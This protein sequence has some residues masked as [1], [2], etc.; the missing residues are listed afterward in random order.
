MCLL[1]PRKPLLRL[2]RASYTDGPP[3]LASSRWNLD[4]ARKA[5]IR[6]KDGCCDIEQPL[7]PS[8]RAGSSA[9]QQ[10]T[11]Q[12][13]RWCCATGLR[14]YQA[15]REVDYKG[16]QPGI[17]PK[18]AAAKV[19][20]ECELRESVNG[21]S[22]L[23][24]CLL[25]VLACIATGDCV[26]PP[27]MRF[28]NA[29]PNRPA[30]RD[31]PWL[32]QRPRTASSSSRLTIDGGGMPDR[33]LGSASVSPSRCR[34]PTAGPQA[35]LL[36]GEDFARAS[37]A[38]SAQCCC[39]LLAVPAETWRCWRP[40]VA[41]AEGLEV[42]RLAS[43]ASRLASVSAS[44]QIL[45]QRGDHCCCCCA[46]VAA[47][48]TSPL[49]TRGQPL[50]VLVTAARPS[51][52]LEW[53]G[54]PAVSPTHDGPVERRRRQRIVPTAGL[55]CSPNLPDESSARSA[56]PALAV[57]HHQA[58][59]CAPSLTEALCHVETGCDSAAPLLR[60]AHDRHAAA[61]G[62]PSSTLA[63]TPFDA[64]FE[65]NC[66]SRTTNHREPYTP[67][68]LQ[69]TGAE[70]ASFRA[71][72]EIMPSAAPVGRRLST[73]TL[74]GRQERKVTASSLS[75]DQ[76]RSK[77]S[78]DWMEECAVTTTTRAASY[79]LQ[80]HCRGLGPSGESLSRR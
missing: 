52:A 9:A 40:R 12:P 74:L 47:L 15:R 45:W 37:A 57:D 46:L 21:T 56:G 22:W 78:P 70:Q 41:R 75:H 25:L 68:A 38:S 65:R 10:H 42:A 1:P 35:L 64:R 62:P 8:E 2:L 26:K 3:P 19:V 61:L 30:G 20:T 32:P 5:C 77:I 49:S 13:R 59:R 39:A 27:S 31:M 79:S 14:F 4:P 16:P 53:Y 36:R 71:I 11:T 58:S 80:K 50:D 44:G 51:R 6:W 28:A 67:P 18:R 69:D 76:N 17:N 34:R 48:T 33:A 60:L 43:A 23:Q 73:L 7:R 66:S 72:G 24:A 54:E 55:S 63:R 29:V